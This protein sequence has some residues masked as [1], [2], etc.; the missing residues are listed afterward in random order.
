MIILFTKLHFFK[1][2]PHSKF[3]IT[4]G[5]SNVR[6][7]YL[8]SIWVFNLSRLRTTLIN[9]LSAA[10]IYKRVN[11]FG[12]KYMHAHVSFTIILYDD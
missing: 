8:P 5:P 10:A 11:S 9:S 4:K 6:V 1:Q 3:Y 12:Q 7:L 2:K